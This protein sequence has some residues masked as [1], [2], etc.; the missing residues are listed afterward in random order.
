M[1]VLTFRATAED[2]LK[3]TRAAKAGRRSRSDFIRAAVLA[4]IERQRHTTTQEAGR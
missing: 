1:Q 3:I 2:I 4:A